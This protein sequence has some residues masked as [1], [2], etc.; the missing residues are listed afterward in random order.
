MNFPIQLVGKRQS[1]STQ[2]L[3]NDSF[4]LSSSLITGAYFRARTRYAINPASDTTWVKGTAE[5]QM[6]ASQLQN[7]SAIDGYQGEA[8]VGIVIDTTSITETGLDKLNL[9]LGYTL[10]D[11]VEKLYLHL[12][13][14]VKTGDPL[15]ETG[16]SLDANDIIA[17]LGY[18]Q[19]GLLQDY[20]F[21][22]NAGL[23][24]VLKVY[25]LF[26][27]LTDVG[28]PKLTPD[29]GLTFTGST[30]HQEHSSVI[31]LSGHALNGLDAYDYLF[32]GFSR[33][34]AGPS[35]AAMI[36]HLGLTLD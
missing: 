25:N 21:Q 33:D 24:D 28:N 26:T 15:V 2:T 3:I 27:G 12:W 16:D 11:A 17:H 34:V 32:L 36:D 6:E 22:N 13:G 7:L 20:T 18:R 10:G 14:V 31:S 29:H 19:D 30:S 23:P 5:W 8:G 1:S 9:S 4:G 35:S